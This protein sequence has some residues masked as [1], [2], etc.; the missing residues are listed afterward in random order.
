MYLSLETTFR[1]HT[2]YIKL[3]EGVYGEN[4]ERAKEEVEEMKRHLWEFLKYRG[5]IRV[6]Y[7]DWKDKGRV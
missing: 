4:A 7:D 3:D 1:G 2:L 6:E 5:Y